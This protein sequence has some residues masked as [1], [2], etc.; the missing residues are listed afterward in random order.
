M[1]TLTPTYENASSAKASEALY[2]PPDRVID[3]A[4]LAA[5]LP[6]LDA[7]EPFI[8]DILSMALTHERCGR[9][10]YRTV[11]ERTNNPVLMAKYKSF[12]EETERHAELLEGVIASMGGNPNYVSPAAR[13]TE[14]ADAKL[15][16]STYVL[17]GSID[18][19]T[20]EMAMLDAVLIAESVDHANWT[21]LA[22]LVDELPEGAVRD[23]LAE[24]VAEVR[25]EE[26]DHLEWARSMR[27][28]MII[29]QAKGPSLAAVGAKV[30]EMVETVRGWFTS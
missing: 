18:V 20:Q 27:T 25:P 21:A 24:A 22:E 9:H 14:G 17:S 5:Q 1:S 28:R 13:A 4:G 30:E 2:V 29:L 7:N 15:V 8:A 16:E 6:D 10:L 11:A 19:I 23:A 26:D 12:G 3:D